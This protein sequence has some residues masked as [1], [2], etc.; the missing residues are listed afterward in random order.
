MTMERVL[1]RC[2][3]RYCTN[4]GVQIDKQTLSVHPSL[5]WK[6]IIL[7]QGGSAALYIRSILVRIY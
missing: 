2:T 6:K 7:V 1:S 5:A 3:Y 4:T